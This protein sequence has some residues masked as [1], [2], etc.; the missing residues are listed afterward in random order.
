MF[1]FSFSAPPARS[2]VTRSWC[3]VFGP[4]HLFSK[5]L[6]PSSFLCYIPIC[7]IIYICILYIRSGVLVFV[8]SLSLSL[9]SLSYLSLLRCCRW[10]I[11]VEGRRHCINRHTQKQICTKNGLKVET[12]SSRMASIQPSSLQTDHTQGSYLDRRNVTWF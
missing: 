6:G 7:C 11:S 10:K 9:L 1:F 2:P 12:T 3:C 8:F 4:L 5:L